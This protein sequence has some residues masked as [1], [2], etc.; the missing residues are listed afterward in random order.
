VA[1]FLALGIGTV[2]QVRRSAF[3]PATAQAAD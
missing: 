1:A 3:L 2:V